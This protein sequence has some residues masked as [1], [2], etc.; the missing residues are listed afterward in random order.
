MRQER[1]IWLVAN[2]ASGS[3]SRDALDALE[4]CCGRT[5]FRVAHRTYFPQDELPSPEVLDAAGI[6][7]VAIFAGDGT[8]NAALENLSGWSGSALVLPGGTMNLLYHRLHGQLDM[9]EVLERVS[10]GK[11]ERRRPGLIRC[12][13]G[14]AYAGL[15]AGPGTSWYNVREAMRDADVIDIASGTMDALNETLDG[16][17]IACVEPELGRREGYPLLLCNPTDKGIELVAF[18]AETASEYAAQTLALLKR[19]FREGPHDMLGAA[20]RLRFASQDGAEYG[21]LIDGEAA[22][23]TSEM[24]F[25]LACADVDLLST[26]YDD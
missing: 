24:E 7:T 21:L 6:D 13:A 20:D 22:K 3:N 16:P 14:A 8:I 9:E 5:G 10:A 12:A 26:Q 11:A 25:T 15:M 19:D 17:Q 18:H 4:D 2:E 23:G 1:A